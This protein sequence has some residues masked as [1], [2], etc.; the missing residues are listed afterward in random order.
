MTRLPEVGDMVLVRAEVV[1]A[2]AGDCGVEL[3]IG[4]KRCSFRGWVDVGD[5]V[6]PAEGEGAAATP[7]GQSGLGGDQ[8]KPN[9]KH[10]E[11]VTMQLP[12][13][14]WLSVRCPRVGGCARR[15]RPDGTPP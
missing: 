4:G 6:V 2:M 10:V 7:S 1:Q 3:R 13:R 8:R 11:V 12:C 9:L 5:L 15:D 14:C